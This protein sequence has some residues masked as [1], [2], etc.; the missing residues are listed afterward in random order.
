GGAVQF[1]GRG[2]RRTTTP[3][4]SS[5]GRP[6]CNPGA[7]ERGR[8][9][10]DREPSGAP[11]AVASDGGG[12]RGLLLQGFHPGKPWRRSHR[13]PRDPDA[14]HT[15]SGWLEQIPQYPSYRHVRKGDSRLSRKK[16]FRAALTS[17]AWPTSSP[18][19]R[20][21]GYNSSWTPR[22]GGLWQ[23]A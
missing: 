9:R 14:R 11:A 15:A 23:S 3:A 17:R 7:A 2:R 19:P 12:H 13:R 20:D 1:V 5:G 4:D 6:I 22:G 18:D 21:S 10:Y 8:P 16:P